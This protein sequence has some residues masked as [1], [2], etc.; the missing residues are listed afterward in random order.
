[1]NDLIAYL[2]TP[3]AQIALIIGL[4]ELVKKLGLES[5]WVPLFDL[6]MG[7]ISGLCVYGLAM[8][9]GVVNGLILGIFMGLSACGLFSGIKN[10]T[11]K[12]DVIADLQTTLNSDTLTEMVEEREI[13]NVS[14]ADK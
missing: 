5:R 4:A 9:Y 2:L 14:D 10:L 1:M 6:F 12:P 13:Y 7:L 3:A 8:G 11:Q